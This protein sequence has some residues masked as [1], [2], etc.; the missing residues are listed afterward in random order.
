MARRR[1]SVD[2]SAPVGARVIA[3][4]KWSLTNNVVIR[5]GTFV[6]GIILARL[7]YPEQYGVFA[8]SFLVVEIALSLNEM[9]VSLAI[10]R[11]PDNP[12]TFAPTA[13]TLAIL[14]SVVVYALCFTLS[15]IFAD[16][17]HVPQAVGYM[18]LLSILVIIDGVTAVPT[19]L[20][21]RDFAQRARFAA[22]FVGFAF[23]TALTLAMAFSGYGVLS[24]V[25]GRVV[26]NVLSMVIILRLRWI[27][28]G[29]N[30]TLA[31][32]LLRYGLPLAGSSLLVLGTMN[33]DYIIVSTTLGSVAL[34]LYSL[35][36][37]AS[38]WSVSLLSEAARRVALAGFARSNGNPD[39]LSR[40]FA[41]GISLVFALAVPSCL[42]LA[43][44]AEPFLT[45]VYGLRWVSAA[46]ALRF[47]AILG[48]L[49]IFAILSYDL[50]VSANRRWTIAGIEFAWLAA[51]IP[52][53]ALG[54]WS[55]GIRGVAIAHV[56]VALLLVIPLYLLAM[57]RSGVRTVDLARATWPLLAGGVAMAVVVSAVVSQIPG[58]PRVQ[59][60]VGV[61]LGISIYLP[62]LVRF[63]RVVRSIGRPAITAP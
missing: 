36:F 22:D 40:Q 60:G 21:T 15:P 20:L 44:V 47:L 38:S 42:G 14:G 62:F 6:A 56:M 58:R 25:L 54:A 2:D 50:L 18:Q 33:V 39:E 35:A 61:L 12:R 48:I 10:V 57:Q 5:I 1:A 4:A 63:G 41:R 37:N 13:A 17:L 24:L 34:G 32:R 31:I 16:L 46:P 26:G 9:G 23:G 51:L 11:W 28:P 3:G 7:L 27:V 53:L 45:V 52:S 19:A 55:D 8:A 49:R 59:L 43:A 29:W 30:R